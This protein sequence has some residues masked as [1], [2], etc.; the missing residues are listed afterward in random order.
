MSELEIADLATRVKDGETRALA[1]AIS[2]VENDAPGSR[3]LV[4]LLYPATGRAHVVA[5]TGPPGVGKSTLISALIGQV[6]RAGSTVGVIAVDPSSP[7]TQGALLGDRIRLSKHLGDP[8]VFVRSMATRGHP[9]GLAEAAL[10]AVL[11]L[12]AAGKDFV[13]V[14]TVGVGQNE[15]GVTQIADTI[16]L[17]L[18][19]GSGDSVQ[20]LKA[21]L[22]EIPDVIAINRLDHPLAQTMRTELRGV[23]ALGPDAAPPIVLTEAIRG[24]GAE[25]LW[26]AIASHR[27]ALASGGLLEDRRRDR[28]AAE[29]L[30]VAS[31]RARRHLENA[32]ADDPKLRD[33]LGRVRDRTLDP[34]TAVHEILREVLHV[35]EDDP[36]PR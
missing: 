34:L 31:A 7:F 13:F 30:S 4:R 36:D 6:R 26:A 9:G 18:T 23:L 29:V 21:G 2:V 3:E 17:A 33:L 10:E 28:I 19:P 5:L 35:E 11:V 24:D 20:A 8:E 14:E 12:D 16:V 32:L 15:I 22:M 25:E 1:K 27:E